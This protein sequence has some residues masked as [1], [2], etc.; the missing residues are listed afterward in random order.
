[1]TTFFPIE[2]D[3]P[4]CD[5]HFHSQVVGSCGHASMRTDFRPNYWGMNPTLYFF[6][7]CPQCGFCGTQSDFELDIGNPEFINAVKTMEPLNE[8]PTISQKVE[9]AVQCLEELKRYNIKEVDEFA[10]ANKW[11]I[12]YWWADNLQELKRYGEHTLSY[13]EQAFQGGQIPDNLI[14]RFI[15][16]QGEI[17]RRLGNFEQ[18][19]KFFDEAL[20]LAGKYPDSKDLALLAQQQKQDPNDEL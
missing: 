2:L 10:L 9:R 4:V 14:L 3:C 11:I 5:R 13:F 16:L 7:V 19:N 1:M 17:N 20:V 18:A 8:N 15:Y 6:H 12:A